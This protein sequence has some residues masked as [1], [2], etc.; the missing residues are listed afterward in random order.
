MP[1]PE[2]PVEEAKAAL[3]ETEIPVEK[4]VKQKKAWDAKSK[5]TKEGTINTNVKLEITNP[6]DV[7]IDDKGQLGLF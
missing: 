4:P 6:D 3:P 2:L 5:V 1:E 7:D